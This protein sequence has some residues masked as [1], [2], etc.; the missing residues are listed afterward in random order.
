MNTPIPEGNEPFLNE[1]TPQLQAFANEHGITPQMAMF[2]WGLTRGLPEEERDART[3]VLAEQMRTHMQQAETRGRTEGYTQGLAQA[4]DFAHVQTEARAHA[5]ANQQQMP[6]VDPQTQL[7]TEG[8]PFNPTTNDNLTYRKVSELGGPPTYDGKRDYDAAEKWI[9][10]LEQYFAD[11]PHFT[12]KTASDMQRFILA[13]QKLTG[14]AAEAWTAHARLMGIDGRTEIINTFADFCAWIRK[15]F[16]EIDAKEKRWTRFEKI[17]QGNRSFQAYAISK[18]DA[19]LFFDPPLSNDFLIRSLVIGAK[20]ELYAQWAKEIN[21]P[22]DI[23]EV[24]DRFVRWENGFAIAKGITKSSGNSTTNADTR[25]TDPMD[26][27][28]I[29]ASKDR[30]KKNSPGWVPWCKHNN[31]CFQCGATGHGRKECPQEK[32]RQRTNAGSGNRKEGKE[33][34]R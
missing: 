31:A 14:K 27:S 6:T 10:Q 7:P 18:R 26:L 2:L 34:D 32:S 13:R 23:D 1:P 20:P 33:S 24:V 21:Q 15:N 17:T 25:Q 5:Q 30:P 19:A 3:R 22:T 12:G 11:E 4:R 9:R 16:S 8:I 28:A 29:I